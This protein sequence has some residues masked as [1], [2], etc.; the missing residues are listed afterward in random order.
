MGENTSALA[1]SSVRLFG[2]VDAGVRYVSN[3][4]GSKTSL[5]SG[6]NVSAR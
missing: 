5:Q 3:D 6:N 2:G 4:A 1:Q